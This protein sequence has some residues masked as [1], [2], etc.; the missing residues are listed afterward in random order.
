MDKGEVAQ[1]RAELRA[2]EKGWIFSRTEA[3]ARYDLVLDDGKRLYRVQV[4]YCDH[5]SSHSTGSV[6]V[7]LTKLTGYNKR[8]SVART[9]KKSEVDALI[10][11]LPKTQKLCW[12]NVDVFDNRPSF[13]IRYAPPK[14]GQK[15]RL[16]MAEDFEW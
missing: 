14:N 16:R 4:K 11:Y 12:F 2:V 5:E 8:G 15:T 6:S 7:G 10:V 3:H 1:L 9:Y 13:S